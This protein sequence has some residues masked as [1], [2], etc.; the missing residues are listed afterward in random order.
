MERDFWHRRWNNNEIHFHQHQTSPYLEK[1]WHQ[2]DI[3]NNSRVFVPLCGKSLDMLYLQQMGYDV[4]GAEI[5]EIAVSAFFDVNRLTAK[6]QN[7]TSYTTWESDSITIFHGDFF[8]ISHEIKN[9]SAIYDRASLV[10]L[11]QPM[12]EK[13]SEHIAS[14]AA[15]GCKIL[16]VTFEYPQQQMSGPPFA[17]HRDELE[18]LFPSFSIK[19]L[20]TIDV[21][22]QYEPL[23]E[24][25][26]QQLLESIYILEK[27]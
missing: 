21:F 9:I 4:V 13:Y 27:G 22:E 15:P 10:A 12:K 16:L 8:A 1:Y 11:P 17:V 24:R 3:P 2:L 25:G 7:Y 14:I 20:E 26:L 6:K 18:Q 5:D 19:H 23:A